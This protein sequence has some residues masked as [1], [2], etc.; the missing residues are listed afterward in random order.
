MAEL[1]LGAL[2][3]TRK[4]NEQRLPIHPEHIERIDADLRARIFLEQG[5][6][7]SV[8]R[9][10]DE[11]APLVGGLLSR[12]ELLER[13]D[14]V[15]L[16]K[17]L[18]ADLAELPDGTILW[19]WPHCVQDREITQIAIDRKLT[20]LAFE[21]M[22]RWADDGSFG[23]HIFHRNNEIAGYASVLHALQLSGITGTY[24]RKLSAAVI[25][26]GATGRGAVIALDA[27]GIHDIHVLTQ[28][29][30]ATVTAPIDP[31]V[32]VQFRHDDNVA[33]VDGVEVPVPDYL[34][35][36]DIVVNCVL[37]NPDD[38]MMFLGEGD[39]A[40]FRRGALI[41]DVSCDEAMG[42][43]FARPTPFTAP[44]FTA[45]DSVTY[46]GVDHSP[47]H[48]WNSATWEISE[49]LLP[50]LGTVLGGPQAWDADE[51]I[52]RCI[53]IREGRVCNEQILSFQNRAPE[54]PYPPR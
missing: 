1:R 11:L 51:T 41:V 22:N 2:C 43:P 32:L 49:A 3:S 18:P 6:G 13:S 8:G 42:F 10:D 4:E 39:V 38:P 54:Y 46:Y 47:S 45:G 17:P 21:A 23:V 27:L 31:M 24:G 53:E 34:A 15:L 28:R 7:T 12:E 16:P 20:L 26:F 37:Q 33:V 19:G 40:R 14:I 25:G 29:P 48:L 44:T 30:I 35:R 52:R 9:G 5:Y 50:Y 36:H